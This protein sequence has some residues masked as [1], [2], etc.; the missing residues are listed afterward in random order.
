MSQYNIVVVS[1][2]VIDAFIF[3]NFLSVLHLDTS[4]LQYN[5]K[6]YIHTIC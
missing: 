5:T 6:M 4:Q 1:L 3:E 2:K